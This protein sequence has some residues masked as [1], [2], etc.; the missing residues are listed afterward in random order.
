MTIEEAKK[1]AVIVLS[2][3]GGCRQCAEEL[4]DYLVDVFPEYREAFRDA[5]NRCYGEEE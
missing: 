1:V 3:D 2:A 4:I 5:F